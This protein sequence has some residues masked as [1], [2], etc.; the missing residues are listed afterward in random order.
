MENNDE[1]NE[2]IEEMPYIDEDFDLNNISFNK[3]FEYIMNNYD[4]V[5]RETNDFYNYKIT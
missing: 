4:K 3:S 5:C 1:M 2:F